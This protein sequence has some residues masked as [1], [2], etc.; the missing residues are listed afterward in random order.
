M[1]CGK[2]KQAIKKNLPSDVYASRPTVYKT[3]SGSAS[4]ASMPRIIV[5]SDKNRSA[6]YLFHFE[7]GIPDDII[8][9]LPNYAFAVEYTDHARRAALDDRFGVIE[10]LPGGID[11]N[12]PKTQV[13]EVQVDKRT[14]RIIKVVY[15]VPYSKQRDLVLA[16]AF[17]EGR[18]K[19]VW[20]NLV[21][22][23]HKTV[24]EKNY[25]LPDYFRNPAAY[26][27]VTYEYV[28]PR[29]Y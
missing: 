29:R 27:N 28:S 10:K 14:E 2:C 24:K 23:T 6:Y 20:S 17:P 22:D 4:L 19:T 25:D 3:G 9:K 16:V 18:V 7:F 1:Q 12:N 21:D 11:P 15:R 5:S 8:R 13:I 26:N